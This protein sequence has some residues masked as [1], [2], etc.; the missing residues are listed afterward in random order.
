VQYAFGELE[1]PEVVS[2]TATANLRSQ[3]VM[4]RLGLRHR[5]ERDFDNPRLPP[6]HPLE[7]HVLYALSN[8]G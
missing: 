8:P 5:P 4:R 2:I 1:V 3:A 7:R 6:G